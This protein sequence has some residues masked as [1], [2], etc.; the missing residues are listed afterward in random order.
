MTTEKIFTFTFNGLPPYNESIK[1]PLN[2]GVTFREI[3]HRVLNNQNIPLY[4]Q[5]KLMIELRDFIEDETEKLEDELFAP[6]HMTADRLN[7]FSATLPD[8]KKKQSAEVESETRRDKTFQEI[9]H[10]LVHSGFLTEALVSLENSFSVSVADMISCRDKAIEDMTRRQTQEM[11]NAIKS[12]GTRIT[13]ED[14]NVLSLNHFD[15]AEKLRKSWETSLDDL[16]E[17]QKAE[18]N[19]WLLK[20]YED[21]RKDNDHYTIVNRIRRGISSRSLTEAFDNDKVMHSVAEDIPQILDESFT[22]NLGAQMKTTHNLRLTAVNV[23]QIC[24][25]MSSGRSAEP[26]PQR[27]QTAMSLYSNALTGLVLLVDNRVNSYTGIKRDFASICEQSADFHFPSFEQQLEKVRNSLTG[28]SAS[29]KS[30]SLKVGD[31]YVTKHSNLSQVHV[32]FHL[33]TDESILSSDI[34]SRH[35][36]M[37]GLRNILKTAYISDVT[38]VSLPLLLSF[39]LTDNM[40]LQWCL[41]RAELVFKCVKGFMIEMASLSPVT[42]ENRTL[43]FVVPEGISEELFSSLAAMLPSI[44][45]LSNPLVLSTN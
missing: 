23:L 15:Q 25:N 17:G 3:G 4:A 24:R 27:I 10:E 37:L 42:D 14:V 44:F 16:K 2:P 28:H 43:Q 35:P 26:T 29:T 34:N 30:Q 38:T 12:V 8:I 36:I 31:F 19:E 39:E 22:I 7:Q 41:K 45:R 20:V 9:Y 18:F 21:M 33:V 6:T 1:L 40:T 13:E 5:E 32:V 11:E